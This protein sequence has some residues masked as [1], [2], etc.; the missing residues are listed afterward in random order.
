M[1]V[2]RD[3]I[4]VDNIFHFTKSPSRDKKKLKVVHKDYEFFFVRWDTEL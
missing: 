2:G 3:A 1:S 4:M